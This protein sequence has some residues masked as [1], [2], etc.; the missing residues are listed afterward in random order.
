MNEKYRDYLKSEAW[1]NIRARKIKSSG[2]ICERCKKRC[3]KK[4][5][6]VHHRTYNLIL[7]RETDEQLI[8]LCKNCHNLIHT[9]LKDGCFRCPSCSEI[10]VKKDRDYLEERNLSSKEKDKFIYYCKK[11]SCKFT[12]INKFEDIVLGLNLEYFE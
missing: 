8:I 11:C 12:S 7:G 2:C 5:L 9:Q 3:W 6:N 4:E 1:K 10:M